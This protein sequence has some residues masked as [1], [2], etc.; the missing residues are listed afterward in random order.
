MT[1]DERAAALAKYKTDPRFGEL[2]NLMDA[3][4]DDLLEERAAEADADKSVGDA[5]E[6]IL[7]VIFG[8]SKKGKK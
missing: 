5:E 3:M 6:S 4:L 7:D 1:K 2:R 8:K